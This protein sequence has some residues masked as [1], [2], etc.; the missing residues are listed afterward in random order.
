MNSF[1][2]PRRIKITTKNGRILVK[3]SHA[4]VGLQQLLWHPIMSLTG[5]L[6]LLRFY[7]KTSEW[8]F[9]F[10]DG[11]RPKFIAIRWNWKA[12]HIL[13]QSQPYTCWCVHLLDG[14]TYGSWHWDI[15]FCKNGGWCQYY[16]M[17]ES[18]I[19]WIILWL[20]KI[21]QLLTC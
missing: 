8:L 13:A 15:L 16:W 6:G 11:K 1:G 3:P 17:C 12:N 4:G 5:L 7:E 14:W 2:M 18:Y 10:L 19:K 9:F 21:S 20:Q